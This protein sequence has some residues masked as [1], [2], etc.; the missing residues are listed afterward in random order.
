MLTIRHPTILAFAAILASSS[1]AIADSAS[2]IPD[3]IWASM[4][5]VSWHKELPCP[6][7]EELRL[8]QIPYVDFNGTRKTGPLIVDARLADEVLAIFTEIAEA[9]TYHIE[10]VQLIDTYGGDDF[11]SIEANN[12]SAFNCRFTTGAKTMSA[13]AKGRAIDLNPLINPYVDK[14]GTSH[15][16]S[17]GFVT[18]QQRAKSDAAGLIK[19]DGVV[20]KVFKKHGWKWGGDWKSIKDYQ[21]FSKDGR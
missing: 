20:V 4:Q 1:A 15:A 12:T 9:G 10:R 16:K 18:K 21:H 17:R 13:H 7:R 6:K 3:D 14:S 5:G 19:G 8:V 2:P 11:K